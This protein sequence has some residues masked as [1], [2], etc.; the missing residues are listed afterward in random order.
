MIGLKELHGRVSYMLG[1]AI[2]LAQILRNWSFKTGSSF[3]SFCW[4][5]ESSKKEAR[6]DSGKVRKR[7]G[8]S[9]GRGAQGREAKQS[10]RSLGGR[11]R[12]EG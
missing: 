3:A 8:F 6:T 4:A 11:K 1:A 9:W 12:R 2:F 7:S 10:R 5:G